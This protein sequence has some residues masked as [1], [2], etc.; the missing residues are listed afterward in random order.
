MPTAAR[1]TVVRPSAPQYPPSDAPQTFLDIRLIDKNHFSLSV[2]GEPNLQIDGLL[3]SIRE[4]GVLDPLIVVPSLGRGRWEVVSGHRRLACALELGHQS[5]PCAIRDIPD[6]DARRAAVLEFNRHRRKSFSQ[7]MR[8]ADALEVLWTT[9]ARARSRANLKNNPDQPGDPNPRTVPFPD[10]PSWTAPDDAPADCRNSDDRARRAEPATAPAPKPRPGRTDAAIAARIGLGGKDLYRQAR[11]IWKAARAGDARALSGVAQLDAE[12]KTIHAAHKDL[13]RRD[14][15]RAD[16]KPTPY[17][18]WSFRHDGAF[19][20][21][22]PGSIPPAIVAHAL[23]YFTRP[24]DLVVDPMAGGGTTLD[25]ALSMDRLCLAY[26]IDPT[27]PEIRPLDIRQGFPPEAQNCQLV[28]CD[29][30]YHTMLARKYHRAGVASA[31]LEEWTAFLQQL[32]RDAFAALQPGGHFALLLATQ[33]EKDLPRGFGYLDHVFLGYRAGTD[34][35]FLPERRISCPMS[36]NYQPQQVRQAR[37]EGRLLG[38]V[39]DLLVLRKP[40]DGEAPPSIPQTQI[41]YPGIT[42]PR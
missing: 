41:P 40:R 35:G 32:A 31:S 37:V 39:R 18:V 1:R 8:E 23:H 36:G 34:A 16:F 9:A 13:R 4:H 17:D 28:F 20:I 22:H 2:Y 6:G 21:P 42:Q 3:D 14:R 5:V 26:D 24:G 15:F 30:P 12:T 38:Q 19:G 29:P 25:V 27:R 33:T 7:L 11:A 10:H